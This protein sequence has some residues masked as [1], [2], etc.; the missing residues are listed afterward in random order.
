MHLEYTPEQ[1]RLRTELRA[2]FA[3]LVPDGAYTRHA[4]PAAQKR[5]YRETIRRLGG[6]GWL[7]V[8]WPEEYGGRGLTAVEQFIFFDEAAQAGVP[9]PLMALN[10][11]GP[12]IMQYGT[13]EQKSYFLPRVLSGELDFAIGYSEPD[14]GTDLA[15]LRTRAV[16]DGDEYVVNGQKIWTT[17]GDTA[18]WVWLAT[19]TDPDAPPHKGITMLLVPTTEPGY[20]CT[21][22]NT[23]ASHDTTASYYENIRVPV[24]RRVGEEN[25]GWRLITNQLNHER[26]TLAAHG[27]MAIRSLHN[28][29]RW[30]METKLADGRR[31]IDLPWVRRLLARTHTR[32]DALRLLNWRMV[33]AVQD[34]TLTPQDASA[35]KVYGSEARRDAYAWLM[36]IVAAAGALKE[37][38]AGTV[39]HGELERGYRSA[40]IFTFGG[41]NNEIQR[42]IISWIGLGMPRVRR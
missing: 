41:G 23:L 17:N 33:S 42:E 20:S 4:D 36:E 24:S 8:G 21:L 26:V 35:V 19:R 5:F 18:D 13:E 3:E 30:A 10:T 37:G 11:V 28:V 38:S 16:R 34:G 22:I 32:L 39:L 14:A 27:T 9:L 12:T 40:V 29:Q 7:G 6:D 1:Q 15:S 31:V 25:K 2:Y